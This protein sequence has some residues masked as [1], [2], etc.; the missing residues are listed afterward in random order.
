[1]DQKAANLRIDG[2]LGSLV[3]RFGAVEGVA[4]PIDLSSP[5]PL[6]LSLVPGRVQGLGQ[7]GGGDSRNQSHDDKHAKSR[8]GQDT[9]LKAEVLTVLLAH[10]AT[11]TI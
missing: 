11:R 9:G 3:I 2:F 8:L 7:R 10:D 4:I 6:D 5:P 1:M